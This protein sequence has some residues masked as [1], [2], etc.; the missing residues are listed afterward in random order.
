VFPIIKY[1]IELL[2]GIVDI[3][4]RREG[5]LRETGNVEQILNKLLDE[6]EKEPTR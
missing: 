3:N 2:V 5:L 4:D 6:E 1:I